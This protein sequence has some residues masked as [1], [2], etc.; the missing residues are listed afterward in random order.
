[1]NTV[2][3]W[4]DNDRQKH[5]RGGQAAATLA[6]RLY[7]EGRAVYVHTPAR[8]GA[9]WLD[10]L[11]V[12]GA[13]AILNSLSEVDPW[14][15]PQRIGVRLDTVQPE[16]VTWLWPGRLPLG[17]LVVLDG[18][19]GLGKST[20]T[21]D[22]A[23]RVSRGWP[24]PDGTGGGHPAG[25]VIVSAEDGVADTIVPRLNAAGADLS[26]IVAFDDV[27]DDKDGHP[28]TIPGDLPWL[29]Q[30]IVQA[31]ARLVVIDP[32]MAFLSGATNAHRDQDVRQA[33][34]PVGK[35]AQR[36]GA[37]I[38]VVRHMN[39]TPGGSAVYR[40]GGSIGIIGAARAGMVVARHPDNDDRRVMA[41]SKNN[42]AAA[43]P[44]V[45]FHM[46]STDTGVARIVWD[47]VCDHTADA[48]LSVP[49]SAD[50]RTQRDEA[51]D[52]LVDTLAD[53][54]V[55]SKQ[56][57]AAAREAGISEMTLRRARQ[58]LHVQVAREGFPAHTTWSLPLSR[59]HESQSCST[60][61]GEH[62]CEHANTT[63]I[64]DTPGEGG[65]VV[66]I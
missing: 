19:P 34:R 42:L 46:E 56:V 8:E 61:E 53:G 27:P 25:V 55:S 6:E 14:Q 43:A 29:E 60:P 62:D 3:L 40:G 32:L 1:V 5:D 24:M 39:K 15:P 9:D 2:H 37:V 16:A 47:G 41:V 51:K 4:A 66:T 23:A 7:N 28:F 30:A 18:D 13:E 38:L 10:V 50:E 54:S 20:A 64:P 45:A 65:G 31:R 63:A 59:V 48:L 49:T 36:T 52:F 17:K 44:S 35:L 22:I 26:R 21:L 57:Q 11:N 33:L 58:D 12:D